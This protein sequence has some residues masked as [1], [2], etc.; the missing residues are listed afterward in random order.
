MKYFSDQIISFRPNGP[1]GNWFGQTKHF[2]AKCFRRPALKINHQKCPDDEP[3]VIENEHPIILRKWKSHWDHFK[4]VKASLGSLFKRKW[5]SHWENP[6]QE[7]KNIPRFPRFHQSAFENV[8]RSLIFQHLHNFEEQ[9]VQKWFTDIW[10]K[11]IEK[12][13]FQKERVK[14]ML[15]LFLN[16]LKSG[17]K[18]DDFLTYLSV[19]QRNG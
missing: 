8:Q 9:I 5:K 19:I 1:G 6:W 18:D 17:T 12:D 2:W 11:K 13:H 14:I 3:Q 10:T 4:K 15:I 16:V 7:F